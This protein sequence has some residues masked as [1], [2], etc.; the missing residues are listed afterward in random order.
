MAEKLFDED[1][2][3]GNDEDRHDEDTGD[4]DDY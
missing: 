2:D 3:N 1:E 4:E